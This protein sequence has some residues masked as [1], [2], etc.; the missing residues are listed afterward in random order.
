MNRKLNVFLCGEKVGVLSENDLLQLSFQYDNENDSLL[1][2]SL[3]LEKKEFS[4]AEAFPF[5]ENLTPEGEAFET[6]TQDHVSGNQTFSI[7]DRFGG[8]CAGAVAFY[9]NTPNAN[10]EEHL[11][12]ISPHKVAEIIDKLPEDPLLTSMEHPPR[13]SLA[14]AQSKFAIYKSNNTYFRSDDE[15]PTT[16]IVKITNTRFPN[17][18]Q[19]EFFCMKLA[20]KMKMTVPNVE[21]Q[22]TLGR[23]YLE[24]ERYD[25]KV[26]KNIVRRIH[27]EDFCQA[28]GIVSDR[29]YQT[30]GGASLRDCFRVINTFSNYLLID[31]QRFVEW[32]IFN[33]LIGNTDAHA[34]NISLLYTEDGIKLAPFY[35]LLSTEVYSEKL[36]DHHS[37][38]LIN[39]KGTYDSLRPKDFAVL[40]EQLNLNATNMTK[41]MKNRF[42][43]IVL[44]AENLRESLK[45]DTLADSKI[46]DDIINLI[47]KRMG[48]FS[49]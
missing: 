35:D 4:H 12:E 23:K 26:E 30:G 18:L 15:H 43:K 39:G 10:T 17:L 7:L 42:A 46:L 32:I 5:F 16:H 25:R 44:I 34:K 31:I 2:V 13:L 28:L 38:M 21:L 24:I 27:Q 40:F 45:N 48:I 33:Y 8:D 11:H 20:Q 6:L 14:G 19:N 9:E 1:S 37:A 3:P 49:V 22:E 47:K 36:I 41:T 29:K